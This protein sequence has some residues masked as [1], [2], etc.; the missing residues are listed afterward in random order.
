[1]PR[2]NRN[3]KSKNKNRSS[4]PPKSKVNP[5]SP[6]KNQTITLELLSDF[7]ILITMDSDWH[8][9][10]G[11]GIPGNVDRL[12]QRDSD[13]IPGVISAKTLT[14]VVRDA[15][16]SVALGL[17]NG[18][19]WGVWS[20]YVIY[21]FGD[22]PAL[23]EDSTVTNSPISAALNIRPA[24]LHEDIKTAILNRPDLVKRAFIKAMT[25]TKP[26]ISIDPV[27]GCAI[28]KF[29]RQEE[30]VRAG[31]YLTSECQLN[32]SE[33]SD[34]KQKIAACALLIA[35]VEY[36]EKLGGKRRRGAGKCQ[37]NINVVK[38]R[39]LW[40][41]WIGNNLQ[42][43]APFKETDSDNSDR[44]SIEPAKNS[45]YSS[46]QLWYRVPL[47]ITAKLP[48][49]IKA[50]TVGNIVETLDY[51]PGSKLL[52][53]VAKKL[54]NMGIN[55]VEAISNNK[56]IIT[57]A[58]VEIDR[59]S[60]RP[61]PLALFYEK[62]SGGF[63]K[64]QV[65]NQ[66]TETPSEDKQLKGYRQGYVGQI[67]RQND[68]LRLPDYAVVNTA[69]QTHNTIDDSSQRPTEEIGGVY[70]YQA[71]EAGTTLQAQLR[72]TQDLVDV[73]E[74][75]D[76]QWWNKLKGKENIGTSKKD[77]YGLVEIKIKKPLKIETIDS[78][79]ADKDSKE[80]QLIIWLL[81]DV[82]IRDRTLRPSIA[83]TDFQRALEQA[84]NNGLLEGKEIKLTLKLKD[85][86]ADSSFPLAY[87]RQRRTESWQQSWCLPRPS[88]TGLMAGSCIKFGLKTNLE[89]AELNRRLAYLSIVGVGERTIE[90]YGQISF[91]DLLLN[92][93]V[94]EISAKTLV[95]SNS[96]RLEPPAKITS[97]KNSY[98]YARSLE[99]QA[100]HN[101]ISN[102]AIALA[103]NPKSREQLLG[104]KVIGTDDNKESCPSMSQL[105]NLR[106]VIS[107]LREPQDIN[108]VTNWLD[109]TR[110]KRA[111]KWE[112]TNDGLDK[113]EALV[114]SSRKIWDKL[115]QYTEIPL[116]DLTLTEGAET[117]LTESQWNEVKQTT[118]SSNKSSSMRLILW[119]E[120]IRT[121]VYE[122]IRAHKREFE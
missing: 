108:L 27:T 39:D 28:E 89:L 32:L 53:L 110:E 117:F 107:R 19:S 51:I 76:S 119:S 15:C 25:L 57:N 87:I 1:M 103:S 24:R 2:R 12:V 26:G 44:T 94:S 109:S 69:I 83:L 36:L 58:T 50:K 6:A 37:L 22:Q 79:V 75:K 45:D 80:H 49:I 35:G 46:Q 73:L 63:D 10:S 65:Y 9:G 70:S 105:G 95:D 106:S 113:I 120:A 14:G 85:N 91:N 74:Q 54:G 84:L 86:S 43:P 115:A 33:L 4:S 96:D 121:V 112:K 100:W 11:G 88:L 7:K 60:G 18:N 55:I 81:S 16:E 66:L 61:V 82:L 62:M 99:K 104:I 40:L 23:N 30:M 118:D 8:I 92:Q 31:T 101:I 47:T 67:E 56:L 3:N 17:D 52:P 78:I 41:N 114:T 122:C 42:P 48:I 71:I 64:G 111:K 116:E 29:L 59:K 13:G 90:G 38:D 68:K 34:E 98:T 21:L 97:S 72:L 20:Q 77:D 102:A 5:S 93:N